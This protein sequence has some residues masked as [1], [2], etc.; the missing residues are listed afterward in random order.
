MAGLTRKTPLRKVSAKRRAYRAS[1]DGQEAL[2]HMRQVKGLPCVICG[3]APPSEAHHVICDRYGT[4]K[5]NDFDTIPLCARHH[6]EGP[7][8]IHNGKASWVAK[9]G[10]DHAYL[11]TVRRMLGKG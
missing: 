3:S 10:P 6:R 8:A 7:D 5:A 9:Y 4:R 11:E 2:E 1:Q